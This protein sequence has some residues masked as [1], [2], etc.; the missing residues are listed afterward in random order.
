[1]YFRVKSILKSNRN[2]TPK[3]TSFL[4]IFVILPRFLVCLSFSFLYPSS[5]LLVSLSLFSIDVA[6]LYF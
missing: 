6:Y 1:M 5:S 3:Q 4:L 2:H